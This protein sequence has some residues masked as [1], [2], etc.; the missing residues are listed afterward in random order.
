MAAEP[1]IERDVVVGQ[2]GALTLH[3]DVHLPAGGTGNGAVV[4]FFHGGGF[5]AGTYSAIAARISPFVRLGYV[6]VAAQYRL[7]HQGAWPAQLDDAQAALRFAR[8]HAARWGAD[9]AKVAV[10]GFSA[11]GLLALLVAGAPGEGGSP[12]AC[13]AYY[14]PSKANADAGGIVPE[15]AGR[16]AALRATDA[17][18]H[19]RAGYPPTVLFHGNRDVTVAPEASVRVYEALRGAGVPAELHLLDGVPHAFDRHP[20]LAEGCAAQA[21][22]FLDR[23]MLNP[24]TY[25]PFEPTPGA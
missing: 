19:V 9:P 16:E 6:A 18:T 17:L 11:G 15:G 12:A 2:A 7:A 22:L 21:H 14:P 5:R 24:R 20:E 25:P 4:V 1:G 23:H 3:A 10:G 8:E 13:L